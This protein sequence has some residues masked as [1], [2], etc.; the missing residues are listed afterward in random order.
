MVEESFRIPLN[1]AHYHNH[2]ILASNSENFCTIF[3][4]KIQ[5]M[6]KCRST[7]TALF[8]VRLYECCAA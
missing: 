6:T 1:Y 4:V 3:G 7:E 8:C 5:E 2:H